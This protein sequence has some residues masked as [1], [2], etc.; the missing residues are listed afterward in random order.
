MQREILTGLAA[1]GLSF[2]AAA[3]PSS[4]TLYGVIDVGPAYTNHVNG[5]GNSLVELAPGNIGGT[6]WGLR[7]TEELG[8]GLQGLFVL[9]SG[10]TPDTGQLAQGGRLFGR[11]ALVGL[12]DARLGQLTLGRQ[13]HTLFD[14]AL[15]YDPMVIATRYGLTMQDGW[16]A[17]RADNAIRYEKQSGPLSARAFYSFGY[18]GSTNG[19]G[20]V[21]GQGKV[22]REVG[23]GIDYASG[24]WQAGMAYDVVYGTSVATADNREQR[25]A[26]G[27]TYDFANA[28]AYLGYRWYDGRFNGQSIISN[29]WWTGVMVNV[30]P[31]VKLTGSLYYQDFRGTNADPLGVVLNAEYK[32][33]KRTFVY[34]S[35]GYTVNRHG[36]SLGVVGLNGGSVPAG[37]TLDAGSPQVTPGKNQLGV[38][39][40]MR[41][42][43]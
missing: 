9:E 6:R 8:G 31:A 25:A 28:R 15:A 21:P 30:L 14:F 3:Q 1:A 10:F 18:K 2:G 4:V 27:A 24:P 39:T 19:A 22:G 5:K 32:F 37:N 11:K 43:F 23:A 36:S 38:A 17:G 26:V 7:G 29:L 13:Q 35:G 33:S 42:V 41:L 40:G 16:F 34:L 20:E 12:K